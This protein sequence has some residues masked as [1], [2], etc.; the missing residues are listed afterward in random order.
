MKKILLFTLLLLTIGFV[1]K[2]KAQEIIP[3]AGY[4]LAGSAEFY[5]GKID[6]D[7]APTFGVSMMYTK[8]RTSPGVELSYSHTSTTGHFKPYPG[9]NL[10]EKKFDVN[11]N[12]LHIGVVKGAQVNQMLYPFLSLS[13]GGTWLNAHDYSTIWR[14]STA[15]GGGA[16]IYF[17]KRIGIML[18]AR[19]LVPMQF[20]G[21]GGWCGIGTG[22]PDCG[23]SVNSYSTIVQGDFTGGLIIKL[24]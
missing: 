23:L 20:A 3:T 11:I 19:L 2:T 9:F 6:F 14:F 18:R 10:D 8:D 17:T 24:R 12:Y 4:M 21:A 22:G 7:N 16:K 13:A 1:R 5:E 15:L